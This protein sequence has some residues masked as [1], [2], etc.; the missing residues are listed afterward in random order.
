MD[1]AEKIMNDPNTYCLN[2]PIKLK[3]QLGCDSVQDYIDRLLIPSFAGKGIKVEVVD[4][5]ETEVYALALKKAVEYAKLT[6]QNAEV[7]NDEV[8]SVRLF[9]RDFE[10]AKSTE[11]VEFVRVVRVLEDKDNLLQDN[12]NFQHG[13]LY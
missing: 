5:S 4:I 6:Y 7:E 10:L 12:A 9:T 1:N 2:I 11:A 13:K 8:K 3:N